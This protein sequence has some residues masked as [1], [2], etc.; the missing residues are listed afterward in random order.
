MGLSTY[1]TYIIGYYNT[2]V[3]ITAQLLTP[4][5]LSVL[6]LYMRGWTFSLTPTLNDRFLREF[7]MADLFTFRAFARKLLRVCRQRNIFFSHFVLMPV[8]RYMFRIVVF[9]T[10]YFKNKRS[11]QVSSWSVIYYFVQRAYI[12]ANDS[13]LPSAFFQLHF[14]SVNVE[15]NRRVS[16]FVLKSLYKSQLL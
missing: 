3:K 11:T 8:L 15:L 4:L 9:V 2:S 7:F 5:M 6:I 1:I 10:N 16:K 12:K 13:A 14:I